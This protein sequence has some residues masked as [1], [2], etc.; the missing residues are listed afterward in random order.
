MH[1]R[2]AEEIR[3]AGWLEGVLE[4]VVGD[5]TAEQ[6]ARLDGEA[7]VQA[8]P[9]AGV[10]GLCAQ[11]VCGCEVP[12]YQEARRALDVDVA[13]IDA[14]ELREHLSDRGRCRRVRRWGSGGVRPHRERARAALDLGQRVANA[15]ARDRARAV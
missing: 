9:D 13:L 4:V 14:E 15:R 10:V 5:L 1:A 11:V 7:V 3:L 6:R 8:R 2:G 12:R